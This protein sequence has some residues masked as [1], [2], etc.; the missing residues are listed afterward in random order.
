[1]ADGLI[2]PYLD[3]PFQHSHPDVLRRMARPA[4]S[5]RTLDEIARW[6]AACPE[7]DACA[8]PS[9][10]ASPARPRPSSPHL[11]DWLEA[12]QLDRVGA[13]RYEN[14]A[15][16][17]R[18]RPARPP[19]RGGQAGALA[20]LHGHAPRRS[21]PRSS[22]PASAPAS[23]SIVDEVDDEAATCRTRGDAP[24]DR[25]QP[26]HRRGLR[27]PHARATSSRSKSRRPP[28]TTSG[29]G[30]SPVSD[31][32][33]FRPVL[34][35]RQQDRAMVAATAFRCNPGRSPLSSKQ[36]R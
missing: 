28:T 8:R 19:A 14:V 17:P 23:R 4:A 3:I 2:L 27:R 25:R 11:L 20:A 13:F 31:P 9:S 29:A 16:R 1:M 26:L 24:G 30:R 21:A 7:L 10:S 35:P 36:E 34:Y 12:A 32:E 5:A 18:Q 33:A 22:P 15:G 6:R